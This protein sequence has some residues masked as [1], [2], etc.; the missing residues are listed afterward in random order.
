MG[1]WS[2]PKGEFEAEEPLAAATRE[3]TEEIG[4]SISG[5]FIELTPI[6]QKS[7]KTVFAWGIE[8]NIDIADFKSNMCTLEWP[9]HSGIF[10]EIPEI[11]KA[12]WFTLNKAK[13]KINERQAA[14][15]DELIVKLNLNIEKLDDSL[16]L[17]K[18][19]S[20]PQQLDLF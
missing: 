12:E 4:L 6:I 13:Q 5:L 2:I 8:S 3:F 11:D 15:I 1:S 14:L 17:K 20:K 7:G 9:I 19:I 18:D 16:P 10:I